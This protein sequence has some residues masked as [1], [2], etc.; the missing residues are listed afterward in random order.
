MEGRLGMLAMR[1]NVGYVTLL[2]TMIMRVMLLMACLDGV[3][4]AANGIEVRI[5]AVSLLLI[6][7][8]FPARI[9]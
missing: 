4:K 7:D 6:L 9:I 5:R 8:H 1:R 3:R 2:S